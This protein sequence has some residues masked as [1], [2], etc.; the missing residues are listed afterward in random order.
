MSETP[1]AADVHKSL[2]VHAHI[3]TEVSLDFKLALD[4]PP[5]AI[6]LIFGQVFHAHISADIGLTQDPARRRATDPKDVSESH[7][8]PF[9]ARKIHACDSRH[10]TSVIRRRSTVDRLNSVV[11][12]LSPVI[13]LR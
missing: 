9:L 6:H 13:C 11:G 1:V 8:Q 5:N 7:L 10:F 3:S 4:H 2:D 12:Q